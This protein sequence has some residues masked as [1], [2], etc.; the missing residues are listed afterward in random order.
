M[1]IQL[2]TH[3]QQAIASQVIAVLKAHIEQLIQSAAT[4]APAVVPAQKISDGALT[5]QGA[6][7]YL[8]VTERWIRRQITNRKI[9]YFTVGRQIRFKKTELEKY[10]QAREVMPPQPFIVPSLKGARTHG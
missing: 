6:A 7:E 4:P 10:I 9:K 5:I 8:N 2:T 1:D 3:D